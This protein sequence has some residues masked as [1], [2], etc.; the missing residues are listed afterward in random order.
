MAYAV[1]R[2]APTFAAMSAVGPDQQAVRADAEKQRKQ[3]IRDEIDELLWLMS[4]PRGRRFM[5][6]QLSDFGVYQLSYVQG[7]STHTAFNEGRRSMALKLTSQ[8]MQHCPSRFTEMSKE[9][10]NHE[11]RSSITGTSTGSK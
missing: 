4:D 3:A 11:R 7:D 9:A 10:K 5:W 8:I 6:R 2:R 1:Q